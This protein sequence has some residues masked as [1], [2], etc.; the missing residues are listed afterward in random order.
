MVRH[1]PHTIMQLICFVE[2]GYY[3]SLYL[4]KML[5]QHSYCILLFSVNTISLQEIPADH[6]KAQT[7]QSPQMFKQFCCWHIQ[8]RQ[9]S[10]KGG[11]SLQS[12]RDWLPSLMFSFGISVQQIA[13]GSKSVYSILTLQRQ[14]YKHSQ[15]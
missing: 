13:K 8:S 15:S 4:S 11:G 2:T 9:Q 1:S 3:A 14:P 5:P 6:S 10:A 7:C 12:Q